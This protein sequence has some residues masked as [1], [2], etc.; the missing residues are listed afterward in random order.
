M[1]TD[2]FGTETTPEAPDPTTADFSSASDQSLAAGG[3]ESAGSQTS[4]DLAEPVHR[5]RIL[6]ETS[7]DGGK[8]FAH[9]HFY[10]YVEAKRIEDFVRELILNL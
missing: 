9:T 3:T 8:T 7:R 6:H 5:F 10:D 1:S 2:N 4:A